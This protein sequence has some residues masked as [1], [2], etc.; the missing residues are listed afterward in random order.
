M[1]FQGQLR[2]EGSLFT[3]VAQAAKYTVNW[4]NDFLRSEDIQFATDSTED[5]L[6]IEVTTIPGTSVKSLNTVNDTYGVFT[7]TTGTTSDDSLYLR[8]LASDITL[9][10]G[11]DLFFEARI[12]TS[13]TATMNMNIGLIN[14]TLGI[15]ANITIGNGSSD[16]L[17][18]LHNGADTESETLVTPTPY[19]WYNVGFF[20]DASLGTFQGSVNGVAAGDPL[21]TYLPTTGSMSPYMYIQTKTAAARTLQV[22]YMA[23]AQEAI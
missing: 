11:K 10:S 22:D 13:A 6:L 21:S 9:V 15:L 8:R 16:I 1:L 18:V 23:L 19:L 17:L 2:G 14:D 7:L 3:K 12:K 4:R 5:W 20:Y